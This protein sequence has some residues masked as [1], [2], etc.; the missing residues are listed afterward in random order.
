VGILDD[1][2]TQPRLTPARGD[3]LLFDAD[4]LT[5]AENPAGDDAT[6]VL[7][8]H[9]AAPT[10]RPGLVETL[11]VYAKVLGWKSV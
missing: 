6:F 8:R 7:I 4:A 3:P 2:H 9:T 5:E 1:T 10:R 11:S